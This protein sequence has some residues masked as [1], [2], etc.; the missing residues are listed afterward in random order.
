MKGTSLVICPNGHS[1]VTAQSLSKDF[2]CPECDD[3][4]QQFEEHLG[5][6]FHLAA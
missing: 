6:R 2:L 1:F 4:D 5:Y 3:C